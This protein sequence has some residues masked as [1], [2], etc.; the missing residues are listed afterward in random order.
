ME[1]LDEV[2][3]AKIISMRRRKGATVESV[4]RYTGFSIDQVASVSVT[5]FGAEVGR[6]RTVDVLNA[7]PIGVGEFINERIKARNASDALLEA[8]QRMRAA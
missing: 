3:R 8:I 4:A 7:E 6:P 1:R 2:D 5:E